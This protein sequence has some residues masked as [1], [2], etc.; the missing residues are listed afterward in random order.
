MPRLICSPAPGVSDGLPSVQARLQA[1]KRE[2]DTL[3]KEKDRLEVE[4]VRHIRWIVPASTQSTIYCSRCLATLHLSL[5][6]GVGHAG[7]SSAGRMRTT[8][9]SATRQSCTTAMC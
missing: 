7:S 9:G 2:E 3:A 4:R 5:H 1:L 6:S 8:A